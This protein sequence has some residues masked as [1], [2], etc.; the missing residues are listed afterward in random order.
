MKYEKFKD[1]ILVFDKCDFC[2]QHIL[3]CGQIFAF[4]KTDFGYVLW[5]KDQ[6]AELIEFS[7]YYE[8]KTDNTD[9]F[10]K[11]F[12]LE[13]DYSKIKFQ[14]C[15]FDIMK[16]P[17]KFGYG[18][19]ILKNDPFEMLISFIISANNNI[20]R[21][22]KTI[23][24]LKEKFFSENFP[25]YDQLL[26]LTESDFVKLG[27]GYRADQLYKALRQVNPELLKE[28]QNLPTK[29]LRNNLI[30]ISGVGPKVADCVL[31]FGFS[32]KDVFPVDTWINKMYNMFYPVCNKREKIRE[33]LI[34]IFK[35]LSGYAQQYLFYYQR[36][37]LKK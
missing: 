16:E 5:S 15:K 17:I 33:A 9:Y 34:D 32:R 7:N 14:L 37:F 27:L 13:N 1:R 31:L 21:I 25:T 23:F 6:K 35:D 3:E 11:F 29:Q 22:Q 19:R 18:I 24:A 2:P 10:E 30:S 4:K 28:W 26:S 8:I 36:S 12:D 20:K